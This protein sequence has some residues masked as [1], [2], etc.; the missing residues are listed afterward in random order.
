MWI[1]RLALRRPYT[2]VV[3]AV[4]IAILGGT[5]IV[6][7]PVDIFPYIDIPIVSVV[8]PYYGLSP[9]EMEKRVVTNFERNLAAGVND[10]EHM[11]SQSYKDIAV[12]RVYFHPNVQIDMAVAQ[13][14]AQMQSALRGMPPG[15]FPANVLKYD[16]GSVPILRL[17]LASTTLRE[18]E[19]F[20]LAQ[21]FIRIPLATVQ[22]AAVSYPF[23]GKNR[24]VMVD[25]NLDELYAKQ[26]SPIDVSNALNLQNL[27]LPAG[28]AKLADIEYQIRVNSSPVVLDELNNLPIKT[29]NGATVYMKDVAQ[30]RD[31]FSVQTNIV[32]TD[33]N[34]G[35]M[36][37]VTRTGKA[38]TL[39]VVN[40]VKA[41]IP[42]I[43][44][45][46]PPE[47]KIN[48][49]GDQSIFV[50]A[51]IDGVEREALIA[52]G[53]TAL[54]ILL[55]LGSWR[56]TLIVCI[57]IPLS[58][59]ASLSVLS[60]LGQ[61]INVMTLGGLALAVG[62]LV[63]DATVAVENTHRNIA[64]RKPLVRAVIDG[65]AQIAIPT[66]VSTLAI[67]IVF[68]PVLLLT[69]TAR[70]LFT[71]LAMAVVFAMLASYIL[72]RTLVPTMAHF[73]LRPEVALY[74]Q[75]VEGEAARG[76]G[77][78]WRL[79]YWFDAGFE[80]LRF[81]YLG[82]LD[83]SLRHRARVLT[84]FMGLSLA[85]FGLVWLIGEDFFPNVD[86]GQMRLEARAPAG[87]RLE[88]T[89]VRFAA[90]EREIRNVIPA[91]EMDTLIDNIG[92]VNC[93]ACLA[94]GEI[95]TISSA[96]GEILISLNKEKHASARDYEVLL[97]KRLR[98][99]FPDTT[100]FFNPANI[101]TQILNF[102]LPAPIDVQVVGRDLNANY[103]IAE[104]L[105]ER[106]SHIPGA[107]DVHVHQVIDQPEIRLNVDRTKAMELG[108]TQRDVTSSM[109][110]S[111]SSNSQ[112]A[113]NYWMNW[114][115]GVQYSVGVQTPQ[116]KMDS[117]D[118]L[119]RTP[120]TAATGVVNSTTADSQ[121][122]TSGTRNNSVGAAPS[123]SS[124]AYG[125]PGAMAGSAQ[126][127]S[128]LVTV[129][130]GAA[131]VIV[132]HYNVQPVFD[133]Y[134][135]VD[136]RD[137]GGVG[138]DVQKI[139]RDQ[140][141]HLPRGT[142][143]TLRGQIETMQTSFFRLGLGMAF[144]VVLVYL[145]MTVNFQSWL[146]PFIILTTLPGAMAGVLW[147]LF[148]TGTTLNVPSLM[149][150]IMCVGVATANSILMVTFA[151]DE[152]S[153]VPSAREAM[154]SA[155]Y[156]RIRPVLMTATAMILGM[157]PMALGLGEG[158]EQNAPLGRAVIGGL[159]FATVTTLFVVP[160]IYTY[161]RT[162]P[163]VDHERRLAEEEIEGAAGSGWS[164]LE[165]L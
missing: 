74:Q 149:G 33:G 82:L 79:H 116:Y 90:M 91:G 71:P 2:F 99:R 46:V 8:W 108:L 127:L 119:L 140:Q 157:L 92:I 55:F 104:Q 20:D 124:Q 115:N 23:G 165:R 32:R 14:T 161:L 88:Q 45:T 84:A 63:D 61:T 153:L 102:G 155:G 21:N 60:L 22:G 35:V 141:N 54:M 51:S 64:L 75:G 76:K 142:T 117:L 101:T 39:A 125:N 26:L 156:A 3:M 158:G 96:D 7:M 81:R 134:A 122:G 131:P 80:A 144:A 146:D 93:W 24:A 89:E 67:C 132:N 97:R 106:I 17:G 95:P 13:V 147:M 160:I 1:V 69:G 18:Q 126:L 138:A 121:A 36:L 28:T 163:P 29:V 4:L 120:L 31:G 105:A 164:G 109:L 9:E 52:A 123:G 86:S 113:P 87:T 118:A 159:L 37:S 6:T 135:N 83:W 162:A 59:L 58:I 44:A 112:V 136:R 16:A 30:V 48:I 78:F 107:A 111:L 77:V 5:A 72:S 148:V 49:L 56:S 137:L 114:N 12:V 130:R 66:F 70:F 133:V 38:S 47:L 15:M 154:L 34:R 73:L 62:I 139:L 100:F 19:I 128:N 145:L 43:L 94:Q 27:I 57:S 103:R 10:I 98:E 50:R 11:E 40:N 42:R 151:N 152:R 150:A 25:L 143:L 68:V 41:A 129:Q 53:L 85:S 65:A 110:I